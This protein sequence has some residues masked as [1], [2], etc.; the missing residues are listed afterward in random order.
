MSTHIHAIPTKPNT[1]MVHVFMLVFVYMLGTFM[2]FLHDRDFDLFF[3][4][5]IG[6]TCGSIITSYILIS[7]TD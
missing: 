2:G 7:C 6:A 4:M 5:I 1:N 3:T